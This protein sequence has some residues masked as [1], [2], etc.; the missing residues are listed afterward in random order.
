MTSRD[1]AAALNARE[2]L[3]PRVSVIDERIGSLVFY[4]SPALRAEATRER[5]A[6][7]T[8]AEA[9]IRTRVDPD[10]AIVAVRRSQLDRFNRLFPR[11]PQADAQAGTFALFRTI[12]LKNALQQ[13]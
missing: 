9:V 6:E 12:T 1:L 4:L 2:T 7:T 13:R 3:P 11:P 8:F 10:D 5:L